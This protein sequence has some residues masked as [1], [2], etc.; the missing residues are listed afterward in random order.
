MMQ[1][2]R[3]ETVRAEPFAYITAGLYW[4]LILCWLIILVFYWREHRRLTALSSMIGTMLYVVFL[5][6]AR[7]LLE[8]VYF[9]TWY[10][11]RT[12]LIPRYLYDVLAE[13][14]NVL[15]PKMLNLF[16]ALMIIGVLVRRWFPDL[17][18]E[19]ERQQRT[20]QLFAQLQTVHQELHTAHEEVKAAQETRDALTHMIV[21][22]MRT[23]LTSVI[24][25]LQTVQQMEE[26]S[27][28]GAELVENAVSGAH[29]LLLMVNDLLDISKMEA[30]EMALRQERFSAR[31]I[32]QEAMDLVEALARDKR[33]TLQQENLLGEDLVDIVEADQEKVRRV[34]VNLLGNAIKFTPEEGT[35]TVRTEW[36]A[37]AKLC[38]SVIDTG[39][40]IP[41][42]HQ[43]RIF[44]KFYQVQP[45][46]TGGVAATGL[47]LTFCKMAV[48]AM[49][50]QIGVE[51]ELRQGSRFWFT[52]PLATSHPHSLVSAPQPHA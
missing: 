43:A 44:Q 27:P 25:G 15:V 35:I 14:Q 7:T 20:E 23:P 5:D 51:N 21:H 8:S 17:A 11:A 32:I 49:G 47:G 42:E 52:L 34:L 3:N 39:L 40:G 18:A 1:A 48:E 13:P 24:S 50:G 29:R 4:C 37:D 46:A 41:P 36:E 12:G 16:A 33:L 38:I 6:G 28:L 45:G 31:S 10:T 26:T 2:R 30:G 19:M 9:G 22:D